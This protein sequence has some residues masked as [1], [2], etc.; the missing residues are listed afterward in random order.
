MD[1]NLSI[2]QNQTV[3]NRFFDYT[4]VIIVLLFLSTF[5]FAQ[6][7]DNQEGNVFTD[8]PF[9]NA[10]FIRLNKIKSLTG[11][12]TYKNPGEAIKSTPFKY[13]Y[14]FD[15]LGRL[16]SCFET[17]KDDGTK[18][19]TWNLYSYS[20][21]GRLTEHRKGDGK[22]FKVTCYEYDSIGRIIKEIYA[23]DY[24][25]TFRVMRRTIFNT[26]TMRYETE[27]SMVKQTIYNDLDLPYL[28]VFRYYNSLGYLI[29]KQ[30]RV[31]VT[32]GVSSSKYEY[33]ERGLL[34]S[35]K[36]FNLDQTSSYEEYVFLYDENGNLSEKQYYRGGKYITETEMIYNSNSN[37][38][39]YVL[40]R[41][42]PT[43]QISIIGFKGY[44]FF[45]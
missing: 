22:G 33:N 17:R 31:I 35:V 36:L 43:N 29:E 7:L 40:T 12:Y 11:N 30:E 23:R 38:L 24:L 25:D 28:D 2:F 10:E 44:K 3:E 39:T 19:T 20:A 9:F 16:I 26:E 15:T 41:D 4:A 34:S 42:V 18:D 8:K 27:D 45:N 13:V 6:M 14:Q 21:Q 37:L 1:N 32:S 5:T